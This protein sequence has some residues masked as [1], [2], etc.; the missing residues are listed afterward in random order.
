MCLFL[1]KSCPFLLRLVSFNSHVLNV[2][3]R[4]FRPPW[5]MFLSQSF[6]FY[7]SL[8]EFQAAGGQVM[9]MV[10]E[11]KHVVVRHLAAMGKVETSLGPTQRC[12]QLTCVSH[13]FVVFGPTLNHTVSICFPYPKH[14]QW[15]P[16]LKIIEVRC[17]S[18]LVEDIFF[19]FRLMFWKRDETLLRHRGSFLCT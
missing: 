9:V 6:D 11:Y 13:V 10:P 1:T 4:C 16:I 7:R 2:F 14:T 3:L 15:Q 8:V 18:I 17:F 5:F 12:F 19:F